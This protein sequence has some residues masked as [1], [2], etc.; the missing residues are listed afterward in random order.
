MGNHRFS[1][2]E[3]RF[4]QLYLGGAFMKTAARGAG[5][6]GSSDQA[7]CNTGRAILKKLVANPQ[8][9]FRLGGPR[10]KRIARLLVNMV[11]DIRPG[12]QITALEILGRCYFP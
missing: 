5:Y 9:L 10:E 6:R 3:M 4:L 12:R 8:A 2:R 1:P 7:L 11:D